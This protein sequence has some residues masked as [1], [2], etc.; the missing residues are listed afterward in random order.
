MKQLFE[1][2]NYRDYLRDY[3]EHKKREHAFYSFRLFSQKAGF[4]SPNFF[5]LV[6]DGKRNLSKESAF[7]FSKALGHKKKE[8]DYFENLVFFNQSKTLEEKNNY[9]ANLMKFRKKSDPQKIE[10]SEYAYYSNWYNPAIRELVTAI[11]FKGDYKKLGRSVVPAISAS[12]AEKAVGLL[13]ELGFI[14]KDGKGTYSKTMASLTTGPQVRSIAVANY[15]KAMMARASE[16]IERFPADKRD[17]SSLTISVSEGT[18]SAIVAKIAEI[19]REFLEMSD[20]DKNSR[21]VIQVNFQ[22]FP[23]SQTI[24]FRDS[25]L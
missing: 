13:L 5:K 10:E 21:K 4:T 22:V 14:R 17:I 16:S 12:D 23:I 3:Y 2:L 18:F 25:D 20:A 7:K 9:L 1:Y 8:A 19:R 6:I 15:H 24:D 11:D